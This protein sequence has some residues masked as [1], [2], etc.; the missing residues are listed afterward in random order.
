MMKQEQDNMEINSQLFYL[1]LSDLQLQGL[2]R[3]QIGLNGFQNPLTPLLQL[4]LLRVWG[5]HQSGK[6]RSWKL[7]MV[8]PQAISYFLNGNSTS[9][10]DE[11]FIL[12]GRPKRINLAGAWKTPSAL[13]QMPLRPV[14]TGEA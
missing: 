10:L 14:K 7:F 11:S 1:I 5:I 3:W 9:K 8:P 2:Y 13:M 12:G 4:Q 6:K